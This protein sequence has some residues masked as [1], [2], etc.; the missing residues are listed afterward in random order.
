MLA[1]TNGLSRDFC[2]EVTG[3]YSSKRGLMRVVN[4]AVRDRCE[5]MGIECP[6]Q[7]RFNLYRGYS[8]DRYRSYSPVW[9]E[10]DDV[11]FRDM[12]MHE[13]HE[14][15]MSEVDVALYLASHGAG[16]YRVL[17]SPH[18]P[19]PGRVGFSCDIRLTF[20]DGSDPA[21]KAASVTAPDDNLTHVMALQFVTDEFV[22]DEGFRRAAPKVE[23]SL[24]DGKWYS[25]RYWSRNHY[26]CGYCGT[27][28]EGAAYRTTWVYDPATDSQAAR[29]CC[30]E[31]YGDGSDFVFEEVYRHT[32]YRPSLPEGYLTEVRG[33][34]V[35][36]SRAENVEVCDVCGGVTDMPYH[37][38]L[39]TY[40]QHC[41]RPYDLHDYG[42]TCPD[43]SDFRSVSDADAV[44]NLYLGIELETR[45]EILCSPNDWASVAKD[46]AELD[47]DDRGFVE[48]KKDC[49]IG[50][51]G[52]EIVSMPATP[53]W[54]LSTDYWP[55]LLNYA[56]D[57]AVSNGE[58]GECGLHIHINNEFFHRSYR[59]GD[60][61]VT[62]DRLVNRFADEWKLFSRRDDV[63][64]D[65]DH[66]EYC[67]F[68]TD[69]E[70][71]LFPEDCARRKHRATKERISSESR[72]RAVNH[73]RE[74]TTE[75]RFF[76]STV[77]YGE[78]RA[79]I[80][81]AAGLAIMARSLNG[82]GWLMEDWS[83]SDMRFELTCALRANN[84]PYEDFN[85]Y[86]DKRGL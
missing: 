82:S 4:K 37:Q 54:H 44:L 73:R 51:S 56:A 62:V 29:H 43:P 32:L 28:F 30:P 10:G 50:S 6:R 33:H 22:W 83:W 70:L 57:R 21:S 1:I 78:L 64:G 58:K 41:G 63:E 76:R 48:C 15:D 5:V 55:D 35:E 17:R 86:C 20:W 26:T 67:Q 25:D 52:V 23:C 84:I 77:D 36:T 72:Y 74:S 31:C 47:T 39:K 42:H 13:V 11:L 16:M 69:D 18:G 66:Y 81:A 12:D 60:E 38:G 34:T 14:T 71:G 24:H 53:L 75:L 7:P 9:F 40:C 61:Q 68:L 80:E 85:N 45:D 2:V 19:E 49:S 79:A 46:V 3:T 59:F 8:Y 65:G 27:E